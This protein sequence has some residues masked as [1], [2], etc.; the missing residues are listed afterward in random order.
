MKITYL[1]NLYYALR[2]KPREAVSFKNKSLKANKVLAIYYN[3]S[4]IFSFPMKDLKLII[5]RLNETVIVKIYSVDY[6]W[7]VS[8]NFPFSLK[9]YFFFFFDENHT[10]FWLRALHKP[11]I[12][13]L[14]FLI[15]FVLSERKQQQQLKQ[16]KHLYSRGILPWPS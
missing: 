4:L 10:F 12:T 6:W 13:K 2:R 5:L 8:H 7:S 3:C 14:F 11:K 9:K 16:V 15:I 1:I